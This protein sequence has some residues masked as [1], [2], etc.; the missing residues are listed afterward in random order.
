MQRKIS[1]FTAN[2]RHV[3][4]SAPV[5]AALGAV[6]SAVPAQ[7]ASPWESSS[8]AFRLRCCLCEVLAR[9]GRAGDPPR[10]D[11]PARPTRILPDIAEDAKRIC[12]DATGEHPCSTRTACGHSVWPMSFARSNRLRSAQCSIPRFSRVAAMLHD[13]ALATRSQ[14]ADSTF[15]CFAAAARTRPKGRP[16]RHGRTTERQRRLADAVAP[17]INVRVRPE[18]ASRVISSIRLRAGMSPETIT[19]VSNPVG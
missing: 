7:A 8:S 1:G 18:R 5:M 10:L 16:K 2:F 11:K 6:L 12:Q 17:H 9:L 4:R 13:I 19:V 15:R 14:L 3:W